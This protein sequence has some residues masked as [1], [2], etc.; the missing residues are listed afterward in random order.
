MDKQYFTELISNQIRYVRLEQKFTQERMAYL[1]GISKKTLS[2]IEKEKKTAS[3]AVIV[4]LC[5]L[6]EES[7]ALKKAIGDN[8][9]DTVQF[10]ALEDSDPPQDKRLGGGIWWRELKSSGP[11]RLQ[12]NIIS[13]HYRI[14]DF[15]NYRYSSSFS[16]KEM[17]S[18]MNELLK[19]CPLQP[20]LKK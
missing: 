15:H 19:Q 5:A 1:L 13:K 16:K 14:L 4:T 18:R 6:F 8:P 12:Q 3:W 17:M 7:T 11:F 9:V 10:I 2:Q 20:I